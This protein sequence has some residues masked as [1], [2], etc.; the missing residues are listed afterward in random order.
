MSDAPPADA[1][2]RQGLTADNFNL[3]ARELSQT[4]EYRKAIELFTQAL[5]KKPDFPIAYNGRGYAFMR[6][7]EYKLAEENYSLAI[8]YNPRYANAYKNRSAARAKLGD[9]AGSQQDLAMARQLGS[10]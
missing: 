6:L 4:G 9:L 8:K 3:L 7:G 5:A 2:S 10:Q 1:D